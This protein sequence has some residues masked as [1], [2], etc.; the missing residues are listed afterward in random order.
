MAKKEDIEKEILEEAKAE[1]KAEEKKEKPK[2]EKKQPSLKKQDKKGLLGA[3]KAQL[4]EARALKKAEKETKAK[5]PT[6]TRI[7]TVNLRSR[8]S[9]PKK[10]RKAV[11][12]LKNFAAKHMKTAE[13][14]A[15]SKEINETLWARGVQ[16]PP[17]KL[18]VKIEQDEESVAT[19]KLK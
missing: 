7:Y 17:A 6:V 18:R 5:K 12:D 9:R 1:A 3:A 16:K 4:D 10:S 14:I 11:S 13:R 15:V 2:K 8:V 19:I